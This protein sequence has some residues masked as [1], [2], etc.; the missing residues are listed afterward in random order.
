MILLLAYFPTLYEDELLYSGIARYHINTGKKS[1]KQTI[2]DLF[3]DRLVCA[4]ADLPSH[5]EALV[6]RIDNHYSSD[7]LIRDH[8]IFPYYAYFINQSK[9]EHVEKLMKEGAAQGAIHASLGLMATKVKMPKYLQFCRECYR[10]EVETCEPYWH[11]SHQIPGVAVCPVHKQTLVISKVECSTENHK[12]EFVALSKIKEDQFEELGIDT[13]WKGNLIYIAEQSVSMLASSCLRKSTLPAYK[14]LLYKKGYLTPKGRVKFERL[15]KEFRLFYTDKLLHHLNCEV[16]GASETWLH[17]IIRTPGEI[18]HPL[19][20]LLIMKFLGDIP[21]NLANH[22]DLPFG[23][24]PWPCLNKAAGHYQLDIIEEC[25]I[26]RCSNTGRPI[27]TF[28]CSCGFV[29]SRTSPDQSLDDKYRIGRIKEFG[30]VWYTKLR[31]VN[32]ANLSLRQKAKELGVDPGTVKNQLLVMK[33]FDVKKLTK[34][35]VEQPK[36]IPRVVPVKIDVENPE[37]STNKLTRINWEKRDELL[38]DAVIK[39]VNL[40]NNSSIPQRIS[41]AAIKR[42]LS[43][44]ALSET[45]IKNLTKLPKT[46]SYIKKCIDT[47][48]SFQIRRIIWAATKLEE[49]EGRVLG[50]RLLKTAG[51]NYPLMKSVQKK[52][53]EII[54]F[55]P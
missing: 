39:A 44:E 9:I 47:T 32:Q 40:I 16:T 27:G 8:T 19:R 50:W 36:Q 48:E 49:T 6:T 20:H 31:E 24:E 21:D 53:D 46:S 54:N 13:S 51:L 1:Q 11:R 18:I 35:I 34:N 38:L 26:S 22:S 3:G 30:Q 52:F 25:K 2:E 23:E 12:F 10:E 7:Q 55:S 29:Y 17:K 45:A 4:S 28:H 5:L 41:V 33:N 14:S 43:K 15:I 42:A 37:L